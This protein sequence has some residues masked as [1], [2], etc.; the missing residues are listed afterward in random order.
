MYQ[1]E[2]A[3]IT[4]AHLREHIK[5]YLTAVN[6][7]YID[8]IKM[9]MPKAIETNNLVGGVYNTDPKGMPAIAIDIIGKQANQDSI[10]NLWMFDY[11]GH[12]A[13]VVTGSDEAQVNKLCKRYEQACEMFIQDHLFFHQQ[14]NELSGNAFTLLRLLF[15][16]MGMSG[17]ELIDTNTEGE[18]VWIAGFRI[19]LTW[20]TSEQGPGQHEGS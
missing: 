9:I 7:T 18:Q 17:A 13:G 16:N 6:E 10:D 3:D 14:Q 20:T 1:E 15:N 2:I 19:D 4:A 11:N 8:R 12:F 5:P